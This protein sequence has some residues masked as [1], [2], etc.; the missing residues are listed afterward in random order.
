MKLTLQTLV[1]SRLELERRLL[2]AEEDKWPEILQEIKDLGIEQKT[3][4]C[5]HVIETFSRDAAYMREQA[6]VFTNMAR[7]LERAET[8]LRDYVKDSMKAMNVNE[9]CGDQYRLRLTK[10]QDKLVIDEETLP[11]RFKMVVMK[12]DNKR[13]RDCL[14]DGVEV[15]GARLEPSFS[16]R[17]Y[18]TNGI[19]KKSDS[20]V[21]ELSVPYDGWEIRSGETE[22]SKP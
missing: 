17:G 19:A 13:I 12:P 20:R 6:A 9:I 7:K 10:T 3:D 15:Q 14:E 21:H 18:V 2:E 5:F 11:E 4:R 1:L 16:L 8:A 22:K